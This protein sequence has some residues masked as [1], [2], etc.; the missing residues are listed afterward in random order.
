MTPLK[1]I[2]IFLTFAAALIVL[3]QVSGSLSAASP[4]VTVSEFKGRASILRH[5]KVI[6]AFEGMEIQTGDIVRTE[7]NSHIDIVCAKKWGFRLM[8]SAEG[9]LIQNDEDEVEVEL[10][11]GDIVSSVEKPM[12]KDNYRIQTPVAVL[13]VRGTKF[14]TGVKTLEDNL[15]AVRCAVGTGTVSALIKKSGG[16]FPLEKG[17]ALDAK[18]GD[19]DPKLRDATAEELGIVALADEIQVSGT[20]Q[21]WNRLDQ[22]NGFGRGPRKGP[23]T[24]EMVD[25]DDSSSSSDDDWDSGHQESGHFYSG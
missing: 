11:Q 14:L 18:E 5:G 17:R 3:A 8:D 1:K 10:K 7:K 6:P 19:M 12:R 9:V 15:S 4:K 13:G 20:Q 2:F 23:K 21:K 16:R 22:L 25:S 24:R